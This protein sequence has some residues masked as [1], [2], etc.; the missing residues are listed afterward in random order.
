MN[1]QN[2]KGYALLVVLFAVVF[3]VILTAVFM[4]GAISNAKQEKTIDQN[5]LVVVAAEAGVDYYTWGI[6][7]AYNDAELQVELDRL[8]NLA[9][10]N[11]KEPNT[12]LDYDEIQEDLSNFFRNELDKKAKQLKEAGHI[13]IANEYYHNL[14]S[15]EIKPAILLKNEGIKTTIAGNI[16]GGNMSKKEKILYFEI[17][18][19]IPNLVDD[20]Q[21]EEIDGSVV[22]KEPISPKLPIKLSDMK[23]PSLNCNGK[24]TVTNT[25]CY[26]LND[27]SN[28]IKVEKNSEVYSERSFS[29]D[30]TKNIEDSYLRSNS[31]AGGNWVL[32]NSQLY[33]KMDLGG[34]AKFDTQHSTIF[35]GDNFHKS[36]T[37]DI[38][39]SQM[40]I[41]GNFNFN[42]GGKIE[43]SV[44]GVGRDFTSPSRVDIQESHITV[45]GKFEVPTGEKIDKSFVKVALDFIAPSKMVYHNS[46]ISIGGKLQLNTG[47]DI[48]N[49]TMK[50]ASD[51]LSST[52]L[53]LQNSNVGIGGMLE[54][55]SGGDFQGS[56]LKVN[57]KII[58]GSTIKLQN[59]TVYS[60][61]IDVGTSLE[62]QDT[63]LCTEDLKVNKLEMQDNKSK[64]YYLN[65]ANKT[66]SNIIKLS[67]E[68]FGK[69][70]GFD[71]E[72]T[73][74]LL[75][76]I[77]WKE[78]NL[79]KVEYN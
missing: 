55:K 16:S 66:G 64:I 56:V 7:K 50:V 18:F 44:I 59:S 45:G 5:N 35:I 72:P 17:D 53:L 61:S 25:K 48:Q 41:E 77:D 36:G 23:K 71:G 15:Y 63:K 33:V 1:K 78:P 24:T 70:C 12:E 65:N 54:L 2:E 67:K 11:L 69:A 40:L 73:P 19:I 9:M 42:S 20:D 74:P 49:T 46:Q 32:R 60:K 30:P 10:K 29:G 52:K 26:F 21:K 58:T 51:V 39:D 3:I 22:L 4:R 47:G 8:I 28:L 76:D 38:Q 27:F 75:S 43:R 68:E 34:Y 6:M 37:V 79:E 13:N 14:N 57:N 31:I 62:L